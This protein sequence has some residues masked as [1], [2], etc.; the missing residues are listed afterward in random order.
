M[1]RAEELI[2]D[3]G[4]RNIGDLELFLAQQMQ[5]QVERPGEGVELDDESGTRAQGGRRSF[6]GGHA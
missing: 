2:G 6:G 1:D 5:Q 3:P 4:D